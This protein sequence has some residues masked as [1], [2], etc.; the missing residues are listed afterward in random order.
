MIESRRGAVSPSAVRAAGDVWVVVSR[1]RRRLKELATEEDLTPAQASVLARLDKH[2]PASASELAAAERVRPQSAAKIIAA[3][4]QAGLVERRPDPED[5]RRQLV[6]LTRLGLKRRQ[7]D[8][9]ARQEWL[10]RALQERCTE[11]Q[12][13]TIIEAMALLDEVAQS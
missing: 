1:L 9:R 10:A 2:G 6:T 3:L 13:R 11:E 4:E 5:G 7:G 12:C 8:R